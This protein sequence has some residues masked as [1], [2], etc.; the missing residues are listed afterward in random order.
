MQTTGWLTFGLAGASRAAEV[1]VRWPSGRTSRL[2]D[3]TA[4]ARLTV[5]E[6]EAGYSR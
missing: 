3:V 4:G 1:I 2:P 6:L 5:H